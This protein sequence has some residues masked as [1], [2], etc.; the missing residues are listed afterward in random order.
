MAGAQAAPPPAA[1]ELRTDSKVVTTHGKL[2]IQRVESDE[3]ASAYQLKLNGKVVGAETGNSIVAI[4]ASYPEKEPARLVLLE[5]GSGGS[6][7]PAFFK[8]LEI[9]AD[10]STVRSK[11][12]GNCSPMARP[13]FSKGVLRID[14]PKIGGA[15][16]QAWRYQDGKL[17]KVTPDRSK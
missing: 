15:P 6:G 11:E 12:F 5:L 3:F 1:P 13:S 16:A 10:G 9:K 2:E 4:A 14:I 8:V 17:S 7:C